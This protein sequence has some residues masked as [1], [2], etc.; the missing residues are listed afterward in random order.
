MRAG[1]QIPFLANIFWRNSDFYFTWYFSVILLHYMT[2]LEKSG[3]PSGLRRKTQ[4]WALLPCR[5]SVRDFW[6]SYEGRGS[7]PLP[8]KYFLEKFRFLL[9][10]IYFWSHCYI[11]QYVCEKSGWPSG[12]RRQTQ[13]LALLPCR[14]SV[15][16]FWSSYEGRGSNP[17][18]DKYFLEKLRFL[19]YLIY[20]VCIV[21]I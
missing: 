2:T 20:F 19:L 14:E 4:G 7:N 13:G 12:L 16:D 5:E 6:S 21:T 18:P 1:V 11:I 15:R 17:L 9:Y 8:E 3:W 10:L